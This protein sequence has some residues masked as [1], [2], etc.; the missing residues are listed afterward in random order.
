MG[1]D[2]LSAKEAMHDIDFKDID[3]ILGPVFKEQVKVVHKYARQE[4]LIMITYSN[5][6]DLINKSGVYIF[7]IVPYQQIKKVV[8]YASN[9]KYS[10]L[11]SVAPEN[12]Y[13][14]LIK[15]ILLNNKGEDHYNIKKIALYTPTDAPIFQKFTL[16]DAILDI[17]SSMKSDIANT[18][19]GFGHPVI[20]LPE[21]GHHLLS[22][23][24][25]LQF[26]HSTSDPKYKVLG[27]GDWNEYV[28]QQNLIAQNAWIVDIPH[29]L[30]YEFDGRF[31]DNY[32][33]KAP[34][35]AAVAY[36]SILL[37]AAILNN[38]NGKIIIQFQEIEKSNGYQGI[39]GTF[40]LKS[41]GV[42]ERLYSVYQYQKGK[43][44]EI[45]PA[46]KGF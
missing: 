2:H 3:I 4:N 11:Y 26:L 41:N 29:E 5:D 43:M 25:Q 21:S 18:L 8:A 10:N 17:K 42:T 24:N 28:L 30:L 7:D 35:I 27:I 37:I 9:N 22:V 13:G 38:S 19:P 46:M 20:L 23:V 45:L 44:E 39:T 34:R 14:D 32:K 6:L 36:D 16:S 12:K 1:S 33:Y 40:R 31:I 15:K